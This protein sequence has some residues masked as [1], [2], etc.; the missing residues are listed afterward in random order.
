MAEKV[1]VVITG[2]DELSGALSGVSGS[3]RG[4][5]TIALGVAAGGLAVLGAGVAGLGMFLKDSV[6]EAMDA[7]NVLAQLNQVI[8]S[9][10]GAAGVTSEEIQNMAGEL[11]KVTRFSDEAIIGGQNLLLTFTNIG[12]D[13]F[14]EATEIMLD[15]SQ[16]LGQDL[17]GSAIQ[18]G[19]ALQDPIMGVNV[20]RRVGVNFTEEQQNVIK[21]L[22]E[23]GDLMGAQKLILAELSKEFGGSAKA[24]GETFAGRLDIL[25]NQFSEIKERVGNALLP[26]LERFA[27]FLQ[28]KLAD[29]RVEAFLNALVERIG[30]LGSRLSE[31]LDFFASGG[32][33]TE[34]FVPLEGGTDHIANLLE[35][36]GVTEDKASEWSQK[37]GEAFLWLK[38]T[39]ATVSQFVLENWEPIKAALIAIGAVLAAA[40]IATAIGSI[41]AA[42]T[43]LA[44]PVGL[45]VVAVGL[46][47]A[48][49]TGNWGGIRDTLMEAWA[50]IQPAI[51]AL[52]EWLAVN[53]PIALQALSDLWNNTLLPAITAVWSF[54]QTNL[55]P[56]WSAVAELVGSVV[57][58]AFDAFIGYIQNVT[59]PV[60]TKL[61]EWF[62]NNILPTIRVLASFLSDQ[63]QPAFG[64]IGDAIQTVIGFIQDLTGKIQNIKLPWFLTPGS[65]TPFELGLIGITD[66]MKSL[67]NVPMLENLQ[68]LS[69]P[70]IISSG[71]S[72]SM[73]PVGQG[74]M[75]GVQPI[76]VDLKIMSPVTIMD[77]E[78]ARSVLLPFILDGIRQ[79][80][81][82]GSLT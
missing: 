64:G 20:L 75:G 21:S 7:Q 53:I 72:G 17:K 49:W 44:N 78:K 48:A 50:S 5:G 40:G 42:V 6:S 10:G 79:L 24:A 81:A 56:L 65:P 54:I 82:K 22:V 67:S 3:I 25:K 62:E 23:T 29:P 66:A 51:T 73:S 14:P 12:K 26:V 80:Q 52:Q 35:V 69:A 19:K 13:V 63:L 4:L 37:I 43:A 57:K 36:F 45:I 47:A 46:L 16:A 27:G 11:Q 15:M 38:D 31:I 8:E 1:E 55:I 58:L 71:A 60:L 18:L 2:K 30:Q 77:E 74:S 32:S 76:M 61:W 41:V 68:G 39:F 28:E 59:I 70:S 34:F 9:T 33:L